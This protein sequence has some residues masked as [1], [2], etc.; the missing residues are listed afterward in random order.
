MYRQPIAWLNLGVAN[1]M[2]TSGDVVSQS[3][4]PGHLLSSA[5]IL[6]ISRKHF[7]FK[8]YRTT[9]I[10]FTLKV[11]YR[12]ANA[13]LRLKE[14]KHMG[15]WNIAVRLNKKTQKYKFLVPWSVKLIPR[16]VKT[17]PR[18][19]KTIPRIVKTVPRIVKTVPRIVLSIVRLV[20]Y[21]ILIAGSELFI[22]VNKPAFNAWSNALRCSG[23]R[24][25]SPSR[26]A[27]AI[28]WII[29]L[30][31]YHGKCFLY[32]VRS[33][34]ARRTLLSIGPNVIW[35]Y[36]YAHVLLGE[37][38]LLLTT[39]RISPNSNNLNYRA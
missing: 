34:P 4:S 21:N 33:C 6:Y 26:T 22:I 9:I 23:G 1:T 36:K 19:V 38:D 18:I 24:S 7:C 15:A 25:C 32:E 8:F 20:F 27:A 10:I 14:H 39:Q 30:R 29:Y 35:R 37:H 2:T 3:Y 31:G 12:N 11:H 5:F 16:I 17:V 13:F 28:E